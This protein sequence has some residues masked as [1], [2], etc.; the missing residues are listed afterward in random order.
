MFRRRVL[1]LIP[2]PGLR[3][4]VEFMIHA[5]SPEVELVVAGGAPASLVIVDE[6]MLPSLPA[7]RVGPVIVLSEHPRPATAPLEWKWLEKSHL[8]A[9][10]QDAID[11]A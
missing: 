8:G 3:R 4:S 2:D 11:L 10:L 6:T 1:I 9:S 7:D 5:Q